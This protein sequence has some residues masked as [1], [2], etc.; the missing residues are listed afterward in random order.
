M[1]T[2]LAFMA[3]NLQECIDQF[4]LESPALAMRMTR[5]IQSSGSRD[6]KGIVQKMIEELQP[7]LDAPGRDGGDDAMWT[8]IALQNFTS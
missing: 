5:E 4:A 8:T 3:K 1:V 2:I 7:M 6:I